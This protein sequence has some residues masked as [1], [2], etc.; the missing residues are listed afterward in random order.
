M[1]VESNSAWNFFFND[2]RGMELD[3][4]V[5]FVIVWNSLQFIEDVRSG[6]WRCGVGCAC[7]S[8]SSICDY[9][10][11]LAIGNCVRFLE[12]WSLFLKDV[13]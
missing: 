8:E 2:V 7:D 4:I 9:C 11:W 13:I 3:A 12:A 1:I 6:S 10:S 5:G